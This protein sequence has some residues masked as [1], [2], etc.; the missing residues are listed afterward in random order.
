MYNITETLVGFPYLFEFSSTILSQLTTTMTNDDFKFSSKSPSCQGKLNKTES[1]ELEWEM[2]A[3]EMIIGSESL[4]YGKC[5]IEVMG[6][7]CRR[8]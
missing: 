1:T 2:F 6:N 4:I 8:R 7:V 5:L 3:E